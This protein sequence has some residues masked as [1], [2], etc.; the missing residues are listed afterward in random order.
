MLTGE[1]PAGEPLTGQFSIVTLEPTTFNGVNTIPIES[2]LEFENINTGETAK[3]ITT[4]YY[5]VSDTT[6]SY[7]G[8]TNDQATALP[9]RVNQIP[10]TLSIG[11]SGSLGAFSY[12]T[13]TIQVITWRL[14]SA[15]AENAKLIINQNI[16]D[17][18]GSSNDVI[19]REITINQAGERLAV[20][21]HY[22][23][24]ST[25]QTAELNMTRIG[26]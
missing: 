21:V 20:K 19:E 8:I 4:D 3:T 24:Q 15:E 23:F 2:T 9:E 25:D 11:D 5:I 16:I 22:L 26:N 17:A 12:N 6:V 13:G 7:I 14:A 18:A 1:N 10:T